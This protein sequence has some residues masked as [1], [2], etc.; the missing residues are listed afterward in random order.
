MRSLERM[1]AVM[2]DDLRDARMLVHRLKE[3]MSDGTREE[4]EI[5]MSRAKERLEMFEKD[6]INIKNMMS[7]AER[8]MMS[9]LDADTRAKVDMIKKMYCKFFEHTIE[10]ANTLKKELSDL[11][12]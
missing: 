10:S 9:D 12:Y 4:Q 5:Y 2:N 11:K 1:I 8:E 7:S 6:V 3:A